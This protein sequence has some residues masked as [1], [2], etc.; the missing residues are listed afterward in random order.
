MIK[1][2]HDDRILYPV[3]EW[4]FVSIATNPREV[5]L[6]FEGEDVFD[7]HFSRLR[8]KIE[9]MEQDVRDLREHQPEYYERLREA[10][11]EPATDERLTALE[12]EVPTI[13]TRLDNLETAV[14]ELQEGQD[15]EQ[16][17]ERLQARVNDLKNSEETTRDTS[18]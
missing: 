17:M 8:S 5:C 7:S 14:V 11:C 4:I 2:H 3:I 9:Q 15:L 18:E 6:L 13:Q 16:E 10:V 1:L 12:N